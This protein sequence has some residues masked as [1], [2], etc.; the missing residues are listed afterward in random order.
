MRTKQ[1]FYEWEEKG[2]FNSQGTKNKYISALKKFA[3][4]YECTLSNVQEWIN[5]ELF[6][7]SMSTK[8]V[9][10]SAIKHFVEF[11]RKTEQHTFFNVNDI[12]LFRGTSITKNQ[13]LDD[14][15]VQKVKTFLK[16]DK[17]DKLEKFIISALLTTGVRSEQLEKNDWNKLSKNEFIII[18]GKGEKERKIFSNDLITAN[19]PIDGVINYSKISNTCKKL[20]KLLVYDKQLTPHTFRYTYATQIFNRGGWDAAPYLQKLLGHSTLDQTIEYI[21][22]SDDDLK[23]V[24]DLQFM[25]KLDAIAELSLK[26]QNLALKKELAKQQALIKQMKASA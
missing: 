4:S 13:P 12:K 7:K 1:L 5:T 10:I 20:K 2:L 24:N 3:F 21:N 15:N 18:K 23:M 19:L 8:N 11:V 9:F 25:D 16:G 17:L 14:V 6:N 26:E 22:L